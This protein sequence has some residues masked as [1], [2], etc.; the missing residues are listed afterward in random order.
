MRFNWDNFPVEFLKDIILASGDQDMNWALSSDD[1]DDIIACVNCLCDIPDRRF[2]MRY[3]VLIEQ[4]LFPRYQNEAKKICQF[5]HL[6]GRGFN[7]CQIALSR[8]AMSEN[9][10][11]A[12][13]AALRSISGQS[14]PEYSYSNFRYTRAVNMKLTEAMEA[15]LYPY[16]KEAIGK[17]KEYYLGED[18][19]AGMLVM[20]TGSGKTRTAVCFLIREMVSRGYQVI[21]LAHRHML[22]D[23]AAEQFLNFAGLSK[24]ENPDIRDYR[25]SCIS[26][27]H[28][29]ASQVD[30][31]EIIVASIASVCRNKEH[32]RRILRHKVMIVVDECHHAH[33][34]SYRDMIRFIRKHRTNVK[35]L[36]LTATPIRANDQDSGSLLALFGNRIVY[37]IAMSTL[38]KDKILSNPRYI[39]KETGE[40]F[41]S[42]IRP[43]E[44][45]WLKRYGELPE[46]LAMRIAHSAQ[47]NRVIVDDYMEHRQEYGKTLIFA[48]NVIHCRL[49]CADLKMRG[50][51]CGCVFSGQTDNDRIIRD[52]KSGKIQVLINVNIMTEGTDVPDIQTV[53]LTRPTQSE[54]FLVQMIGRGMRGPKA[55]GGT[56]SVNI[57]DFHDTWDVFSRWLNPVWLFGDDVTEEVRKD[58]KEKIQYEYYEWEKCLKVYRR[59]STKNRQI[60]MSTMLPV[61]WYSLIDPDGNDYTMLIFENQI[62]GIKAL[63]KDKEFW[64]NDPTISPETLACKYFRNFAE[65]PSLNELRMLTDNYRTCEE[66][67]TIRLFSNRD[68]V[69]PVCIARRAKKE[70]TDA[71]ALADRLYDEHPEAQDIY[72]SKEYYLEEVRKAVAGKTANSGQR[73]EE[74]P[75]ELIPYDRTHYYDL[76]EQMQKVKDKMFNGSYDGI[77]AIRWTD[78]PCKG[79]FGRYWRS[80]HIIEINRVLDSKDVQEEVL[81]FVIYHEMLHRDMI[82]HTP[83]FYHRQN[84]FPNAAE[85]DHF[86][87]GTMEQFDIAEW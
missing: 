50:V 18:G 35:L 81:Q 14:V 2:V 84:Q 77:A 73:I 52:F 85:H 78:V 42:D 9:L 79:F 49:L 16:Q 41:E 38:I 31:H 45:R 6:P 67:P 51:R 64:I 8:K 39:R 54:G 3:R 53:M 58:K 11:N 72:G 76:E 87:N 13:I 68:H 57:V 63:K 25:I 60:G 65:S 83:E 48:L 7:D 12:Y 32:L 5:L 23:Q 29:R 69:D 30:K 33:A 36:G 80:T 19:N 10:A 34:A 71:F 21:W 75:I 24:I 62:A 1:K 15:E 46:S 74:L 86:L 55:T 66:I 56:E 40:T 82:Y 20:P 70:H 37:S 43:E 17:L 4:D 27:E 59:I 26:G 22:L 44:A 47:R 28:L 61:G